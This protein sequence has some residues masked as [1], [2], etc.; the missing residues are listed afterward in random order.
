MSPV[1]T[2][3]EESVRMNVIWIYLPWTIITNQLDL[4]VATTKWDKNPCQIKDK[5]SLLS[6]SHY[7]WVSRRD[8]LQSPGLGCMRNPSH[9]L[10]MNTEGGI[11]AELSLANGQSWSLRWFVT[12]QHITKAHSSIL[13]LSQTHLWS[14]ES[15]L[16]LCIEQETLSQP[17]NR[18]HNKEF[19]S[20]SLSSSWNCAFSLRT[21]LPSCMILST[22]QSTGN[23]P[24]LRTLN[25]T[26][27][28]DLGF[29]GYCLYFVLCT[30]IWS[31]GLSSSGPIQYGLYN[32]EHWKSSLLFYWTDY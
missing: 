17:L 16:C 4:S 7:D 29:R 22:A 9:K 21:I 6:H 2:R 5:L 11:S 25:V 8:H 32:I 28:T 1:L 26:S 3:H 15:S 19:S 27:P 31:M 13:P 23:S 10:S 24:C 14:A 18:R 30:N 20:V 12:Q